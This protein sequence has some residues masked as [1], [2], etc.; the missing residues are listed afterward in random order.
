MSSFDHFKCP[1]IAAQFVARRCFCQAIAS[2]LPDNAHSVSH[3]H[4][5]ID[6]Q[7][8]CRKTIG[9]S[10]KRW[11]FRKFWRE[12]FRRILSWKGSWTRKWLAVHIFW[13]KSMTLIT[14]TRCQ[15]ICPS[16]PYFRHVLEPKWKFLNCNIWQLFLGAL[17]L[18]GQTAFE[19]Y[20][21]GIAFY[22]CLEVTCWSTTKVPEF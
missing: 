10:F 2:A 6:S 19:T 12:I 11:Q 1:L 22:G 13:P 7:F 21:R 15:P 17:K 4:T 5:R 20:C 16:W 14:V 9:D 3:R 8:L 18:S